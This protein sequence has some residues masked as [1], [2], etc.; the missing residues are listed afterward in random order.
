MSLQSLIIYLTLNI[1][2]FL[3]GVC[4]QLHPFHK[5]C[6]AYKIYNRKI[7][8]SQLPNYVMYWNAQMKHASKITTTIWVK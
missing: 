8:E 2:I 5:P 1:A 4:L 7:E 6:C 3:I